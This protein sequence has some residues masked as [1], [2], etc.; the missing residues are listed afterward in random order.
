[1]IKALISL[2]GFTLSLATAVAGSSIA[3]GDSKEN[4]LEIGTN[5]TIDHT[6]ISTAL[7]YS[8]PS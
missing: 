7:R 2:T 8:E 1:M 4:I 5:H 3:S 6:K